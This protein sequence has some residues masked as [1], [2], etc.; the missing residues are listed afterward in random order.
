MMNASYPTSQIW[1]GT[2]LIAGS[3]ILPFIIKAF[4]KESH[5]TPEKTERLQH[6]AWSNRALAALLIIW[7]SLYL[8]AAGIGSF[9][10]EDQL[11][12]V[13]LILT[14]IMYILIGAYIIHTQQTHS[15][16]QSFGLAIEN[17]PQLRWAIPLYLAFLPLLALVAILNQLFFNELLHI[18]IEHQA[19]TQYMNQLDKPLHQIYIATAILIAPLYEEILFRGILLPKIIQKLGLQTPLLSHH[20]SLPLCTFTYLLSYPL[21]FIQPAFTRLLVEW[22]PLELYRHS[23]DLQRRLHRFSDSQ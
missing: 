1:V 20:S 21:R 19:I 4:Q 16:A 23:H 17:L 11:P 10:Y 5:L 3:I 14:Y 22:I 13:R 15:S 9:F 7:I 6:R 18:E 8:L 12:P 2:L